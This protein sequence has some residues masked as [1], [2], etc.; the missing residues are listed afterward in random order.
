MITHN[1]QMKRTSFL[2]FALSVVLTLSAQ[3]RFNLGNNSPVRKLQIAE[4]AI[5]NLYVDSVDESKLVEEATS[6][7]SACS[8]I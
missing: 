2:V 1:K 7:V 4:M 3:L 5:S 8:L 6:T